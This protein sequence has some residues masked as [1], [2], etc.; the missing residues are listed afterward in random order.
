MPINGYT[1]GRDT[2]LVITD[3]NGNPIVLSLL[4]SF[5]KKRLATDVKSKGLDGITRE[6]SFPDGWSG[7]FHIDR[8]DSTIDDYFAQ[9]DT[10]YYSGINMG[11]CTIM[12]T[13]QEPSG[14]TTQWRY[15]GVNLKLEDA[16]D[17]EG[18]KIVKQTLGFFASRRD[19]V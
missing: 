18:D 2:S 19:K 7:S 9:L 12:E 4:T 15:T 10:N 14:G 1:V 13:I 16:G 11:S 3:Q 6:V 8:Q 17:A 5:K